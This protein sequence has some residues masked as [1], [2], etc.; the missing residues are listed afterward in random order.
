MDSIHGDGRACACLDQV[1][2]DLRLVAPP[3]G[4]ADVLRE[5]IVPP[6]LPALGDV[7]RAAIAAAL[8]LPLHARRVRAP[9]RAR[10]C[11]RERGA[12]RR[13]GLERRGRARD[14]L[15]ARGGEDV[16]K[17]KGRYGE[18]ATLDAD[19]GAAVKV[20]G[21]ELERHGRRHEHDGEVRAAREEQF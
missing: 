14:D 9:A 1:E 10:D 11:H 21:E 3:N 19:D 16:L 20:R 5:G 17:I 15:V 18:G 12:A 7:V 2:V 6:L 8:L 4:L 13:G